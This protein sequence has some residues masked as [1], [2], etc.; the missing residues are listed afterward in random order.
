MKARKS[1]SVVKKETVK[2]VLTLDELEAMVRE[3]FHNLG[4]YQLVSVDADE[5]LPICDDV[6]LTFEVTQ[7]EG[8]VEDL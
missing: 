6:T 1:T 8:S 5:T 7:N 3:R 2:V 4:S